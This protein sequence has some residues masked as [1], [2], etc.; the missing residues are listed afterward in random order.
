MISKQLLFQHFRSYFLDQKVALSLDQEKSR[1]FCREL[2]L[3][4]N[5]ACAKF[6]VC[7]IS[8]KKDINF[9]LKK[10][11]MIKGDKNRYEDYLRTDN[12]RISYFAK[13]RKSSSDKK[14]SPSKAKE[15]TLAL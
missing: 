2:G 11:L 5:I 12:N 1:F 6:C 10:K 8:N 9:F 4:V 14:Q 7:G 15:D 3:Y 13:M